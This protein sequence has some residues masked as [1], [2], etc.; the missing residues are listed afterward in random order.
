MLILYR[1]T[2]I[3][4]QY[5]SCLNGLIFQ[6]VNG[7]IR[8][9]LIIFT[10]VQASGKSSYYLLNFYQSHLRIN[11]DMLK[12]RHR[13]NILFEAGLASKTKMV[14]DNTNPMRLDRERYIQP[15]K[16]AGFEVICYFF[17]ADLKSTLT[18]NAQ[19][20]GKASIPE[21]GVRATYKKL[22]IPK[23]DE[24]FSEIHTVRI[25]GNG[26]FD[27]LPMSTT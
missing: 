13:E 26:E 2:F 7:F 8:M 23:F 27:V 15:A 22:E 17:E 5:N 10:G 19:R 16:D 18:R 9:Q 11:L 4:R 24:G 12:T 6:F 1:M 20:Q 25:I 14:I 21:V 3:V